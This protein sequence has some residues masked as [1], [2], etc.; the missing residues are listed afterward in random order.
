LL[1]Q[2]LLKET[3]YKHIDTLLCLMIPTSRIPGTNGIQLKK[4]IDFLKSWAHHSAPMRD[5]KV[6]IR[7]KRILIHNTDLHNYHRQS[8]EKEQRVPSLSVLWVGSNQT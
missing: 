1:L 7:P 6:I 3:N 4:G 2:Q 8:K 5:N